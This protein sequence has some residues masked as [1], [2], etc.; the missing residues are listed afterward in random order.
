MEFKNR[1]EAGV[2]LAHELDKFRGED[3]VVYALPRGGVPI[4]IEVAQHLELPLDLIIVR[5][6]GHPWQPEC[7]I[8]AVTE[9]GDVITDREE[10]GSVDEI[11]L[12]HEA[13][14]QIQE[15]RRRRQVY[16]GGRAPTP[17][18]GK[19]A[20]V[21]DDGIATGFTLRA[22]IASARALKP[23]KIV[24]AVP[25][26]PADTVRELTGLVDDVVVLH[27]PEHFRG[28]IG[29]Y[30]EDFSQVSDE[31]VKERLEEVS[32]P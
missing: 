23:R 20:I 9:G 32:S 7:A 28:A 6:I 11:W 31:E 16:L 8:G 2:L 15:A 24:V 5:K 10:Y 22:A 17:V 30:Y 12:R 4:G 1:R 3:A 25:V 27:A 14:R 21:V 18:E 29:A 26:A 19:T 13:D